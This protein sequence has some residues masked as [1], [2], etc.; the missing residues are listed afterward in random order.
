MITHEKKDTP[1]GIFEDAIDLILSSEED[2]PEFYLA[3]SVIQCYK[4]YILEKK[5]QE[6]KAEDEFLDPSTYSRCC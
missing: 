6:K 3:F 5:L 1:R 4:M 2:S